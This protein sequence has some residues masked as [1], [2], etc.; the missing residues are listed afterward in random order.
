VAD[1]NLMMNCG[2][3]INGLLSKWI[4]DLIV[5]FD[6]SALYPSIIRAFNIDATTQYGR[7]IFP[8]SPPTK[9][10][11]KGGS[12]IDKLETKDMIKLCKDFWNFP[13]VEEVINKLN[14]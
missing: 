2:A 12:F 13:S 11:D 9:D 1:S 4:W 5:D 14:N 10:F 6:Y 7:L 8:D 3:S